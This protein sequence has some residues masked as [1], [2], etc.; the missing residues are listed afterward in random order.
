MN[1]LILRCGIAVLVGVLMSCAPNTVEKQRVANSLGTLDAVIAERETGATVATPTVV[2]IL[3]RKATLSGDPILLM[4]NVD[5]IRVTWDSDSTL[6]VHADNARI[7]RSLPVVK[8]EDS[9]GVERQITI[10]LNIKNV[11]K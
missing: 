2:Y 5:N 8:L 3:R 7:F 6:T 10:R 9:R 1:K 11:E 4:D